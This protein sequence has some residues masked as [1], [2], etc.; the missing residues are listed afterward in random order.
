MCDITAQG[1][2]GLCPCVASEQKTDKGIENP[3]H[4]QEHNPSK[5]E[6]V[7]LSAGIRERKFGKL[8]C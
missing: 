5:G 6:R 3:V 2:E 8:L 4:G 1:N 7:C